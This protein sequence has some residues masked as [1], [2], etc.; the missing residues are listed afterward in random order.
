MNALARAGRAYWRQNLRAFDSI[1]AQIDRDLPTVVSILAA[2]WVA[3]LIML[4]FGEVALAVAGGA[5][6]LQLLILAF[7][8]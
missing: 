7:R 1:K 6:V 5:L 4:G 3:S 8:W 2:A